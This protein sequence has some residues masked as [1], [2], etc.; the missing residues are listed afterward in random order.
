MNKMLRQSCKKLF[1]LK[2][3]NQERRLTSTYHPFSALLLSYFVKLLQ[4]L[5]Q[6]HCDEKCFPLR[7]PPENLISRFK[8]GIKASESICSFFF[9]LKLIMKGFCP[10]CDR[11][12][13]QWLLYS[14]N[15][16]LKLNNNTLHQ[17]RVLDE[18]IS[19]KIY[20]AI[21]SI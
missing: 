5:E 2:D 6:M 16:N 11:Y 4:F 3:W 19:V 15:N 12:L 8:D 7:F 21:I 18:Y 14:L 17:N 9:K 10:E 13:L 1:L 20:S